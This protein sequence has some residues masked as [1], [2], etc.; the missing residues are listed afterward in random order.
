[1]SARS[2]L[3]A[4]NWKMHKNT[5][6]VQSFFRDF[7]SLITA[8]DIAKT[9]VLVAAPYTLLATAQAV[10]GP[11][12]VRIA[13]QNVH[14]EASGAFTGEI[15]IGMLKDLG[16]TATLIGHSERRQYFGETDTTVNK[17][18]LACLQQGI[19]PIVCVGE[20]RVEREAGKTAAV[21]T[22]Q[23]RAALAGV[24]DP[25]DL[26]IAYEPVWAIGTGLTATN[27]QAQEVHALIR[28][29]LT[30]LFA[31]KAQSIR[32]LYGGSVKP[33]NIAGLLAESDIDGGLVGG[34]SLKVDEF[35]RLVDGGK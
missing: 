9:E 18:L 28:G 27:A 12:G 30:E 24:V 11:L 21:V 31:A 15:S 22:T 29:L 33:D 26:V 25:K 8:V 10:G 13:A 2:T 20:T 19:L 34:A 32:I 4:G 1:M 6:E 7:A 16:V 35:V 5:E 3:I 14:F 17:K 23:I